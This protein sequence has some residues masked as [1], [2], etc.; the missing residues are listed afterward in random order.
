MGLTLSR[1]RLSSLQPLEKHHLLS[2]FWGLPSELQNP[3]SA[4]PIGVPSPHSGCF[5]RTAEPTNRV[6][7][8][9]LRSLPALSVRG[10]AVLGIT[11]GTG[12]R[13]YCPTQT[14]G[15]SRGHETV[16]FM[17]RRMNV[18]ELKC[19]SVEAV[20]HTWLKQGFQSIHT[21]VM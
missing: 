14:S 15:K 11:Q 19:H 1:C 21:Q 16:H 7:R 12:V 10:A 20:V 5:S 18:T 2:P 6:P 9:T 3:S 4:A 13:I 17:T 8:V